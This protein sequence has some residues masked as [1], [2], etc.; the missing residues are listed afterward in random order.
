MC[1]DAGEVAGVWDPPKITCS[2]LIFLIVLDEQW[3]FQ[4][5]FSHLNDLIQIPIVQTVRHMIAV[6]LTLAPE[7]PRE[8]VVSE[9]VF[10]IVLYD[11]P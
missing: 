9:P 6:H 1:L 7:L 8:E 2:I 10:V 5:T 3:L 4:E 11:V